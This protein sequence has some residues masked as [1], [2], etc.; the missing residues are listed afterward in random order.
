M[1]GIGWLT[2][3]Q[4]QEALKNGRLE[5]AHRLLGQSAA[6]GHKRSFELLQQVAVGFV[7]RGE[8]HLRQHDTEAAWNDLLL[9]EQVG[10]SDDSAAVRLRQTL[11]QQ[12]LAEIR[13][14]L[15]AGDPV[16][17]AAAVEAL[18]GRSV[19]G[20]EL[21]LLETAAQD[22]Q[23]ARDQADR[24]EF[25]M[26][27]LTVERLRRQLPELAPLERFEQELTQ[28]R[29]AC[30]AGLIA[31]HEAM[32]RGN[33]RKVVEVADQVL[34][35]AP[36]H[37]QARKARS[38]AWR[39]IEPPTVAGDRP[40]AP[41]AVE[42]PAGPPDRFMLWMDGVGGYLVCLGNRLSLGQATSD[43]SADVGFYADISRGHASILRDGS[44][45]LIEA[46]RPVQVNSQAI[47]KAVLQP[48]D[49]ITLGASCQLQFSQP[50]PVSATARLDLTSGH[51][52]ALAVDAVLLMADTLV[53]GPG[54]QVHVSLP[55]LGQ[56]AV[57]YRTKDGLGLRYPGS[58]NVDGQKCTDRASLGS[59]S[60]VLLEE[61]SFAV[62]TVGARF[63]T[64]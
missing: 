22:W 29:E 63:G 64:A 13:K 5:E 8:R 48:G 7:Q 34:A 24:G 6:T 21:Q 30:K 12:G 17:A 1:L 31:L 46:A 33:W 9:A 41:R 52:L 61:Y 57:L 14:L 59:N 36:Q 55:E 15:D 62:E 40:V 38:Q 11:V 27:L 10:L 20:S 54:S 42:K 28:R 47:E 53:L 35:G 58:F 44:T 43:T 49:R 37:G 56:K 4:A 39:A 25:N 32:D 23:Q 51:R 26:A 16:R 60:R 45:Y 3:R 50:V 2:I 19:R 18:R